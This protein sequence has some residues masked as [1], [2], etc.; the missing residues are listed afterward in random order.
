MKKQVKRLLE[1]I[2][3]IALILA[4][5]I[6]LVT[7]GQGVLA[8]VGGVFLISPQ[9]GRRLVWHLGKIWKRVKTWF[10]SWRFKRTTKRRNFVKSRKL[11]R[12]LTP[13]K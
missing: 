7:P 6:M 3:G 2:G 8:I 1:I 9:H 4:G 13:K 11:K 10:F 5:I 12:K